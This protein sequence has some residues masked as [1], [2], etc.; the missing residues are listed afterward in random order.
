MVA[1][2]CQ[3][4]GV[5][6]NTLPAEPIAL[7]YWEDKPAKFRAEAFGNEAERPG[8]PPDRDDPQG[9]QAREIRAYLRAE[10]STALAQMLSKHPGR[11]MLYWPRTGTL[12]R[13]E[14]APRNARP[15]AW[16]ADRK[17]LLFASSHRGDREQLYEYHLDRRDLSPVTFGPEEHV[18][19]AYD[20]RGSLAIHQL[21]GSG[22]FGKPRESVYL[23]SA[24]GRF[25]REIARDVPPGTLRFMPD[26]DAIVYEQVRARQRSTGPTVFESSVA[27][28]GLAEGAEERVLLRGREPVL[29]PDGQW[30]VFASQSSA[31]YR[32]RRMRPDGTSRVPIG[33]GGSEE[34]MPAVSPDGKYIAFIQDVGGSRRLA[35]RRFDGKDGEVLLRSG[36]SEFPVW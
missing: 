15:L 9:A 29:A 34:R 14:A 26:G 7:L 32:L 23:A 16:S 3:T 21:E 5:G 6:E 28:R 18:V 35:L 25:E 31:G 30:I 1:A 4:S 13:V 20:A 17:R 11:L 24:G 36:W 33:P 12:E 10:K 19:G 22:R 2:G 8:A 27:I